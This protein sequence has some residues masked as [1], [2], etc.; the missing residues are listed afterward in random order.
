MSTVKLDEQKAA[1]IAAFYHAELQKTMARYNHIKS[2][3]ESLGENA[4]KL[5]LQGST[6]AAPKAKRRKKGKPGPASVWDKKILKRLKE[7][8]KPVTYEELTDDIMAFD[9]YPAEKRANIKASIIN[10]T[11]RLRKR[12]R[13]INTFSMGTREK[14]IALRSWFDSN[15]EILDIYKSRLKVVK[16]KTYD[17]PKRHQRLKWLKR[18][19]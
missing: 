5:D 10:V 11:Y 4:P 18:Q 8:N 6:S 14:F 1:E 19:A 9:G 16:K 15:G 17:G 12:D 13:K 2:T 3:L 7:I